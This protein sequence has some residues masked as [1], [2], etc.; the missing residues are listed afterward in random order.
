MARVQWHDQT[1]KMYESGLDQAVI[2]PANV[3]GF[4]WNGLVSVDEASEGG[5]ADP[6]FYDGQK[7]HN[8]RTPEQFAANLSCYTYPEWLEPALGFAPV[9]GNWSMGERTGLYVGNQPRRPFSMVYRTGVS[10]RAK[11]DAYGYKLH[12]IYNATIQDSPI[13]RST[14][15]NSGTLDLFTWGITTRPIKVLD[16][17]FSA[18]LVIDSTQTKPGLMKILEDSLYGSPHNNPTYLDPDT[19]VTVFEYY[20]DEGYGY[21]PYGMGRYGN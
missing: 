17:T 11:G 3:N 9:G 20:T 21:G 5:E 14:R 8:R 10:N 19:L 12:L 4:P 6:I 16:K 18:H 13:G 2:Y 7:V 15:D 1:S